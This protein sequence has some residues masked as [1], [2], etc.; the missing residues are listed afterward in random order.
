VAVSFLV[1]SLRR[2]GAP[3]ARKL[4]DRF[5]AC[6]PLS[7]EAIPAPSPDPR[8]DVRWS[9]Q[10]SPDGPRGP[11]GRCALAENGARTRVLLGGRM[12]PLIEL[13]RVVST[14]PVAEPPMGTRGRCA[15]LAETWFSSVRIGIPIRSPMAL[16]RSHERRA[17]APETPTSTSDSGSEPVSMSCSGFGG[18]TACRPG[19]WRPGSATL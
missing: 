9:I 10:N 2:P 16:R 12:R 19:T 11:F 18:T 8:N 1:E 13:V 3:S 14:V 7:R 17:D 15:D 6:C 5:H 4:V